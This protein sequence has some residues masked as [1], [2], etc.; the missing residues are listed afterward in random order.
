MTPNDEVGMLPV[1]RKSLFLS[2]ILL[3]VTREHALE[4]NSN[5][6]QVRNNAVLVA[7]RINGQSAIL[8]L[9]TGADRSF[10]DLGFASRA[11]L[12]LTDSQ[13]VRRAYSIEEGKVVRPVDI[14]IQSSRLADA[15]LV[16]TDLGGTSEALGQQIDGV[17]GIDLMRQFVITINY[18]AGSVD[19]KPRGRIL[20][21]GTMIKLESFR[22]V[23]LLSVVLQGKQMN[24]LLDTG[25]NSSAISQSGWSQ[26]LET[27]SSGSF[28]EGIGS[29]GSPSGEKF[30][31]IREMSIGGTMLH[32]T[33]MR[34][35]PESSSG[36]FSDPGFTGL[37]GNDLLRQFIVTLDLATDTLYLRKDPLYKAD[38]ERF[39]TIGIQFAKDT[40]GTFKVMA[41]WNPSPAA[42]AGVKI[43]DQIISVNGFSAD[44]M[45]LEGMSRQIHGEPGRQV[46]VVIL[47][48]GSQA[49]LSLT[50]SELL[51]QRDM[52]RLKQ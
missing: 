11:G 15:E 16:A 22:N 3:V 20:D 10:I 13:I 35:A 18:S 41:V 12:A 26:L 49:T 29:P 51:C 43:G 42:K 17:L 36:L 48:N 38:T 34:I 37:V 32:K 28:V 8:L 50:I 30:V 44:G 25:S 27:S 4:S 9:D 23:Y 47:S 46:Q 7:A 24:L 33:P 19:F 31:C 45:S 6:A 2:I 5:R 14:E 1:V 39:S 40:S 52:P 21:P